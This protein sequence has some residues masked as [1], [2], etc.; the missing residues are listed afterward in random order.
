MLIFGTS[1]LIFIFIH[2]YSNVNKW[3]RT[4]FSWKTGTHVTIA[5]S[6]GRFSWLCYL[7]RCTFLLLRFVSTARWMGQRF[8]WLMGQSRNIYCKALKEDTVVTIASSSGWFSWPVLFVEMHLSTSQ[9]CFYWKVDGGWGV[10]VLWLKAGVSI[11]KLLQRILKCQC[12]SL[13]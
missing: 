5:S 13:T 10:T 7:W 6:S 2:V 4:S 8:Y 11:A 1:P 12:V 9:A 3:A